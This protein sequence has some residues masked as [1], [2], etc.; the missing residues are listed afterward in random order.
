MP[1]KEN[2]LCARQGNITRTWERHLSHCKQRRTYFAFWRSSPTPTSSQW[3][4]IELRGSPGSAKNDLGC[5]QR[6]R[7]RQGRAYSANRLECLRYR[8]NCGL[9]SPLAALDIRQPLVVVEDLEHRLA[10]VATTAAR[11]LSDVRALE[12]GRASCRRA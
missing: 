5:R 6:D 8:G 9:F 1:P 11:P 7:A 10:E 3:R 4:L 12:K 2:L